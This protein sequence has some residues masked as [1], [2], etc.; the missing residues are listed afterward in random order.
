[1]A[2]PRAAALLLACFLAG[3]PCSRALAQEAQP[4]EKKEESYIPKD[5][6][7]AVRVLTE[8]FDEADKE[9]IR[10]GEIKSH[11]LFRVPGM[12]LRNEWH[13]RGESRL[14]NYFAE[15]SLTNA[16]VICGC[17]LEAFCRSLRGEKYDLLALMR[18]QSDVMPLYY[19]PVEKNGQPMSDR[20]QVVIYS[21]YDYDDAK[22]VTRTMLVWHPDDA[23]VRLFQGKAEPHEATA[24]EIARLRKDKENWKYT[25]E[26]VATLNRLQKLSP[27]ER[28]KALAKIEKTS[29]D[30]YKFDVMPKSG[31]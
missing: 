29:R 30:S 22:R 12:A 17:I 19:L 26:E 20:Q 9:K 28:A 24:E 27:A 1:M 7:D 31:D 13:L 25:A 23:K 4:A 15:N 3:E 2:F 5:L 10:K 21:R 6:D 11:D 14:R 18:E 8:R 16:D